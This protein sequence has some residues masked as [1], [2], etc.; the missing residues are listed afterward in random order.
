MRA[1][2]FILSSLLIH[3]V[4]LGLLLVPSTSFRGT[5]SVHIDVLTLLPTSPQEATSRLSAKAKPR[6]TPKTTPSPRVEGIATK[7]S[8]PPPDTAT[9]SSSETAEQG[10][11]ADDLREIAFGRSP[12]NSKEL[13]LARLRDNL[14]RKQ[15]Y[16]RASRAFR[17]EG[18]VVIRLTLEKDGSLRK[19]EM[20]EGSPFSRLNDAAMKA[21]S[22]AAPFPAFPQDLR[23]SSWRITLPVRFTLAQK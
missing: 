9:E 6:A 10:E 13:Y 20:V 3:L 17:E 18:T 19:I 8:T 7:T 1:P 12:R 14:L 5:T 16:P 2:G 4:A 22:K 23:Y 11:G 15:E 21:A